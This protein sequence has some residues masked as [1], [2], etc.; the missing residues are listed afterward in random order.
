[1]TDYGAFENTDIASLRRLIK[2]CVRTPGRTTV[3][4]LLKIVR[5]QREV[6]P[7]PIIQS[8]LG[9]PLFLLTIILAFLFFKF[10]FR[11]G[12]TMAL[13]IGVAVVVG[14]GVAYLHSTGFF[15]PSRASRLYKERSEVEGLVRMALENLAEDYD[16]RDTRLDAGDRKELLRLFRGNPLSGPLRQLVLREQEPIIFPDI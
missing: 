14:I 15:N 16:L 7:A 13:L 2:D 1:M 6:R 3:S 10:R 4:S 5:V 9:L 8:W 11:L 12:L